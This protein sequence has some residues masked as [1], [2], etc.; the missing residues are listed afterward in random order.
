MTKIKDRPII[1]M[2]VMLA[3]RALWPLSLLLLLLFSVMPAA[4]NSVAVVGGGLVGVE[5]MHGEITETKQVD[6][7]A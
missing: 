1:L 6:G 7:S 3:R 4:A 5:R 2:P